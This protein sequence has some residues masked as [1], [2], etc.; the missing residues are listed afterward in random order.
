MNPV[1]RKLNKYK[2]ADEK[3]LIALM[4][5]NCTAYLNAYSDKSQPAIIERKAIPKNNQII[6]LNS[7]QKD[8][9]LKY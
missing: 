6:S 3:D 8:V 7:K 1:G 4:N 5:I 9:L 2:T